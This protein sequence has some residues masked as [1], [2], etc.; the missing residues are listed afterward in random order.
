MNR[1]RAT[2]KAVGDELGVSDVAVLKAAKAGR[3][4]RNEDGTF[5]ID[6]AKLEYH[7][8]TSP[9]RGGKRTAGV[10]SPNTVA[11]PPVDSP[12]S[13]AGASDAATGVSL[14]KARTMRE[15]YEAQLSKLSYEAETKK[16][17]N[18]EG[19]ERAIATGIRQ[20]RD[21]VLGVPDR[22]PIDRDLQ[23]KFRD[24]LSAALA[25][26]VKSMPPLGGSDA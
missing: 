5:D 24:A 8:N 20:L 13:R 17:I 11:P 16:L 15:A 22:L 7:A 25:D 18:R 3:I 26:A 19:A 21:A 14:L 4:S 1:N 10:K 12:S 6:K 9:V 2:A 23:I